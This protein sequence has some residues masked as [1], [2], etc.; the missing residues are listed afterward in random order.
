MDEAVRTWDL[1]RGNDGFAAHFHGESRAFVVHC[2]VVVTLGMVV[3]SALAETLADPTRPAIPSEQTAPA[4]GV[5]TPQVGV[6]MVVTAREG[7][8][9]LYDGRILHVGSRTDGGVVVR[10]VPDAVFVRAADGKLTRLALY[11][12][13]DLQPVAPRTGEAKTGKPA[14]GKVEQARHRSVKK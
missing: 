2:C 3:Q 9:A 10:I 13:V 4:E 6:A 14:D 8:M 12:G 7:V 11:P 1:L 5:T